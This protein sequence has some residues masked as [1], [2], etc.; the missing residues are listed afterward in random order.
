MLCDPKYSKATFVGSV[1]SIFVKLTGKD[2]I[3]LYSN[4]IFDGL[5]ISE[6]SITASIGIINFISA[7]IGLSLL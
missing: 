2:V 3:F 7:L 1:I 6:T 4:I 5:A